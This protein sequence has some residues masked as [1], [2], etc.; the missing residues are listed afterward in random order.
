LPIKNQ[1]QHGVSDFE[2]W[3]VYTKPNIVKAKLNGFR[4]GLG[5]HEAFLQS[6]VINYKN[7]AKDSMSD[8]ILDGFKLVQQPKIVCSYVLTGAHWSMAD[9]KYVIERRLKGRKERQSK[10]NLEKKYTIQHHNITVES[11]LNELKKHENDPKV[12]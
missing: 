4:W 7:I 8:W 11:L 5:H 10:N 6:R 3:D 9:P 2:G 1:R 12:F